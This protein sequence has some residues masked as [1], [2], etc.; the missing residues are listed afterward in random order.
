M[1]QVMYNRN[2]ALHM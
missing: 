1:L 2:T